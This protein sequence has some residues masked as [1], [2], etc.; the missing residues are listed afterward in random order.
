MFCHC[1]IYNSIFSLNITSWQLKRW[2]KIKETIWYI[3]YNV[4]FEKYYMGIEMSQKKHLL[5]FVFPRGKGCSVH[6]FVKKEWMVYLIKSFILPLIEIFKFDWLR[7]ILYAAILCFLTNL[8]FLIYP[9]HVIYWPHITNSS[10]KGL[11]HLGP[12]Q[13]FA[14][15]PMGALWRPPDP[16]QL[17]V[18]TSFPSWLRPCSLSPLSLSV[19]L[20]HSLS[21]SLSLIAKQ[22][23]KA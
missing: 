21:L 23:N 5:Y 4:I 12:Y 22:Y 18:Y 19:S 8:I 13:G 6:L 3:P 15:D 2:K 17:F 7:Q 11:C 16:F 14:L 20:S 9:L 1:M 10:F